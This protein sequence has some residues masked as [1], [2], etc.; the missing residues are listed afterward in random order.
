V[1]ENI[2]RVLVWGSFN[3]RLQKQKSARLAL[4]PARRWFEIADPAQEPISTV[5]ERLLRLRT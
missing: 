1:S 2:D 5:I 4:Q 3:Y